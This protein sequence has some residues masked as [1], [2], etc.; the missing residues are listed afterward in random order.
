MLCGC[1]EPI[2]PPSRGRVPRHCPQCR[3]EA[4]KARDR[5]RGRGVR[6]PSV[7]DTRPDLLRD[8]KAEI[9][10]GGGSFDKIAADLGLTRNQVLS[11]AY[12]LGLRKPRSNR[13]SV[14][15]R[16][17]G[18]SLPSA[19]RP[20]DEKRVARPDP[21]MLAALRRRDEPRPIDQRRGVVDIEDDQCRWPIGDPLSP[22]FHFCALPQSLG[23]PYC[24]A[25]AMRA[26]AAVEVVVSPVGVEVPMQR[27]K[28][29]A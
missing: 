25:H 28:I 10:A 5:S 16:G 8:L 22:E 3:I 29:E 18:R 20:M 14:A 6:K 12:R 24:D 13:G 9:A 19:K 23:K 4:R 2:V 17:A 15:H 7:W 11:K 26:Y 21:G 1:G 27:E